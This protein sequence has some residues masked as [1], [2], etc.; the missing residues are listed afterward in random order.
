M[1]YVVVTLSGNLHTAAT[2]DREVQDEYFLT[3]T[4]VD[5]GGLSCSTAV[6]V[7]VKDVND[8]P[9]E[10]VA[11]SVGTVTVPEDA[12]VGTILTRMDTVDRDVGEFFWAVV[13]VI[14]CHLSS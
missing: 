14:Y 13:G 8:N 1:A 11:A 2:L 6:H 7:F 4:V 9:P 3:A 5:G 12:G 10:F